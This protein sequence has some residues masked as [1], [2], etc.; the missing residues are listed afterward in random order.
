MHLVEKQ[1]FTVQDSD[2]ERLILSFYSFTLKKQL[3]PQDNL[4][5]KNMIKSH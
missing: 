4:T 2:P 1:I 3:C 5:F